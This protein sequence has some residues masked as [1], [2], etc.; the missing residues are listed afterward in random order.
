MKLFTLIAVCLLS[1]PALSQSTL[2]GKITYEKHQG[3]P[4][5]TGYRE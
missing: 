5:A 3:I 2:K 1:L 4:G